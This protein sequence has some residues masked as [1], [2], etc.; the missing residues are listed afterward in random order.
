MPSFSKKSMDILKTCDLE[1]QELFIEVVRHFDCSV[2]CGHR[3]EEEQNEAFR[4]N[5]STKRWPES[6][7]NLKPSMAVDVVPYPIDWE[8]LNRFYYFGGFVKGIAQ[9]MGIKIR[10]GGDWDGD[11]LTDDQKFMDLPHYELIRG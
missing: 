9:D 10:W 7:H 3:T 11:T 2:L 1:L 8:N 5:R 4:N 6:K